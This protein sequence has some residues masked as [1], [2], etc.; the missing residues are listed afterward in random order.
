MVNGL[1]DDMVT[2]LGGLG[3]A[4]RQGE[5]GHHRYSSLYLA[6]SLPIYLSI[7]RSMSVS[8]AVYVNGTPAPAVLKGV[9]VNTYSV[10]F[11]S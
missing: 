8:V 3:A 9:R 1:G 2:S 7:S 10:P 5:G 6:I 11:A 4:R